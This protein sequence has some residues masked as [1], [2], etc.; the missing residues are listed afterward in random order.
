MTKIEDIRLY[1]LLYNLCENN[2]LRPKNAEL[3]DQLGMTIDTVGHALN[4]LDRANKI[5]RSSKGSHCTLTIVETGKT[6]SSKKRTITTWEE[7]K[8]RSKV[9]VQ[10]AIIE[11]ESLF[12]RIERD[13]EKRRAERE[14]WLKIEQ[15]K[16]SLPRMGRLVDDMVV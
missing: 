12:D 3:A 2:A 7:K 16:Y 6:I 4:R 1:N 14:S 8:A 15:E 10:Q 5:K 13:Q 11:R 9:F